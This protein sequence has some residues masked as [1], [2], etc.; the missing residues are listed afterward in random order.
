VGLGSIGDVGGGKSLTVARVC[1]EG[2]R[3]GVSHV[4]PPWMARF[5][6]PSEHMRARRSSSDSRRLDHRGVSSRHLCR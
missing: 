3:R 1:S 4:R 2:R 6:A 5:F